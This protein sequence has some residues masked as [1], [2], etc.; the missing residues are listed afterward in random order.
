MTPAHPAERN[1]MKDLWLKIKV[2]TKITIFT[3]FAAYLLIFVIENANKPVS[4]WYWFYQP[5]V[6]TTALK[7]IIY[8]FLAG[9]LGT[10]LARMLFRTIKQIKELQH[11]S[12]TAQMQKD[13]AEMKAKASMLQT[14]PEIKPEIKPNAP[15]S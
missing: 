13:V 11:R 6:D 7:L 1:V 5:Q 15:P 10:L 2:W 14:R 9:V 8:M 4:I 12:A 3:I